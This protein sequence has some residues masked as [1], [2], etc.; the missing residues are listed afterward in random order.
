MAIKKIDT[1][2]SAQITIL[3][4]DINE[5]KTKLNLLVDDVVAMTPK[6]IRL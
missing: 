3:Q 4:N 2:Q 5:L 1:I 6:V